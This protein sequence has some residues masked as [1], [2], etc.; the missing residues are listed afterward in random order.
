[1]NPAKS[2]TLVAAALA[3]AGCAT[4]TSQTADQSSTNSGDG[5]TTQ[6]LVA[7]PDGQFQSNCDISLPDNI[8][9]QYAFIAG[10]DLTNTGNIGIVVRVGVRWN[11]ISSPDVLA[12]Q[13]LRLRV[14]GS[15]TAK[16]NVP[17]T[18]DQISQMQASPSYQNGG[19]GCKVRVNIIG[20]FGKP[21]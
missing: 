21:H 13:T 7:H 11:Q 4:T 18:Q 20:T 17:A 2:L 10:A 8:N 15:R 5:Q 9:G 16:F 3:V 12:N 1:M 19:G 6:T 14:H